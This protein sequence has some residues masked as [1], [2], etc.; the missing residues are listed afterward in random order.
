ML[1]LAIGKCWSIYTD[2]QIS[3]LVVSISVISLAAAAS[4][5][6]ECDPPCQTNGHVPTCC[7]NHG[8]DNGFC[9]GGSAWCN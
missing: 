1:V 3:M 6:V 9:R 4:R 8:F 5:V 2:S 7:V